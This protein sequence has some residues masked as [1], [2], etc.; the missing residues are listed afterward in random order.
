MAAGRACSFR[1]LEHRNVCEASQRH[2]V[3]FLASGHLERGFEAVEEPRRH[4][5]SL[6]A[7]LQCVV[8]PR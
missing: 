8:A 4:K 1:L 6:P 3:H 7:V 2:A 5:G